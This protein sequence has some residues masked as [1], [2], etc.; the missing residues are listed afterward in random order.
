MKSIALLMPYYGK[1]PNY[2]NLWLKSAS[3]NS[4]IDFLIITDIDAEIE[5]PSNVKIINMSFRELKE[6]IQKMFQFNIKLEKAYKLCDYRPVYGLVFQDFISEYDFWG[7]CD[8]DVIWGDLRKFITNEVL[9]SND[10]VYTR[11]HLTLYRNDS[12]INNICIETHLFNIYSFKEAFTTNYSCHFDE[13]GGVSEIFRQRKI[14]YYDN[15][16]FA[17]I[18]EAIFHFELA[19]PLPIDNKLKAFYWNDGKLTGYICDNEHHV[20]KKEYAYI[21]LQK[22]SMEVTFQG[23]PNTFAIVPNK[24][25]DFESEGVDANFIV[26]NCSKK[27]IYLDY[28]KRRMKSIVENIRSG[29]IQQRYLRYRKKRIANSKF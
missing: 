9:E 17:D 3:H 15:I 18:R 14:N 13:W 6:R 23:M 20:I 21:H 25:L 10:K 19:D 12:F 4:T 27:I 26:N 5:M 24:F 29:A 1:Y 22:R 16:D 11:G 28:T 8:P 7:H 2:F